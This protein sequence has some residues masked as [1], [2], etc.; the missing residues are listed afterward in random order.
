[1]TKV[2]KEQI[3]QLAT[4]NG[5]EYAALMAFLEVEG[6]GKGFDSATGKILIQFEPL[7]FKKNVKDWENHKGK[8][9]W[10]NNK[11]ENQANEWA[12]FNDAFY[13]DQ[14]AAML[15]TSI[16]MCQIMGFNF[17]QAGYNS[18]SEMWDDFKK[19]EYEQVKSLIHFIKAN[20][21]L[22]NA[23]K[24][25]SWGTVASIYN[26]AG[27]KEMARKN[28]QVPYDEKL[29]KAYVKYSK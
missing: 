22:Y 25:K 21:K 4:E 27:Y 6:S 14:E 2:T 7:W 11:V 16:G 18:V 23:V 13:E 15:S 3:Q 8:G 24:S 10:V 19:G 1:M 26:G 12:A 29:S 5:I 28:N 20:T 17:K 9:I